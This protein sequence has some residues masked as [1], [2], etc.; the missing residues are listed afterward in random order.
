MTRPL[1]A[2]IVVAMALAG[3]EP[4]GEGGKIISGPKALRDENAALK[5]R[6]AE[7]SEQIGS[8]Q[9]LGDKRLDKLFH[10]T[11]IELGRYTGGID[12]DKRPGHDG[13]RVYVKPIDQHGSTLKAAGSVTVQIYDLALPAEKTL[14]GTYTWTVGQAAKMWKSGFVAYQYSL[15][16]PW[17]TAPPKHRDL[18]VR[19]TFLDY[20]TGKTFTAQKLCK[21]NLP[22]AERK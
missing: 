1:T 14:I 16:C 12:I 19:V 17:K 7:Q 13:V 8:L 6:V 15:T 4:A 10:V 2:A 20:L 21:V 11:R 18:T 22:L 5:A 3:C 9:A